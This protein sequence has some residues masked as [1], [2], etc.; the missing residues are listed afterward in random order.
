M[1]KAAPVA[2]RNLPSFGPATRPTADRVC[3]FPLWLNIIL[4]SVRASPWR[5]IMD[6]HSRCSS[7]QHLWAQSSSWDI[8]QQHMEL[9]SSLWGYAAAKMLFPILFPLFPLFWMGTP[10]GLPSLPLSPRGFGLSPLG[11]GKSFLFPASAPAHIILSPKGFPGP[12]ISWVPILVTQL[13]IR[14]R[15]RRQ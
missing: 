15:S 5:L 10:V 6:W 13:P 9:C 4:R 1:T 11:E 7:H 8:V 3:F 2:F 12:G 14:C